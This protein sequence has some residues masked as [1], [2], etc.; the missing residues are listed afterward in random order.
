MDIIEDMRNVYIPSNIPLTEPHYE[1][2][3]VNEVGHAYEF[4]VCSSK[5]LQN[6]CG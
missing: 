5:V 3:P 2:D 4:H 1:Q 6:T